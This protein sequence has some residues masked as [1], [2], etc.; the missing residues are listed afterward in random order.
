MLAVDALTLGAVEQGP[1]MTIADELAA[2]GHLGGPTTTEMLTAR[3]RSA[4]K[5]FY[6]LEPPG[7][8]DD[9]NRLDLLHEFLS[10][11]L[12]D[13]TDALIAV[14]PDEEALFKRTSRIMK[15][16]LIDQARKTDLGAIRLRLE[17]LLNADPR[18]LR[19]PGHAQRSSSTQLNHRGHQAAADTSG[20]SPVH[21][22]DMATV[23][24]TQDS[25]VLA[26]G[27]RMST[28]RSPSTLPCHHRA[29]RILAEVGKRLALERLSS[30]LRHVAMS[31]RPVVTGRCA[32]ADQVI[33]APSAQPESRRSTDS[34]A[35]G[36]SFLMFHSWIMIAA[37]VIY[38]TYSGR[39]GSDLRPAAASVNHA[40]IR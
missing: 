3:W 19:L 23:P 4:T 17:E 13:L 37:S 7:G 20:A 12:E 10:E 24:R 30:G 32:I 5:Q 8:W 31:R 33:S 38:C 16:W 15:N 21:R 35:T 27:L 2:F 22:Y 29:D 34:P 18:F 40:W 28:A 39:R 36:R 1:P 6:V 11:R 25:S 26:V 9:D 14:G